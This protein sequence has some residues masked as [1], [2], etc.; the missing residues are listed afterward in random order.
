MGRLTGKRALIT[1]GGSGIGRATA[2]LFAAE[3]ATVIAADLR[4]HDETASGSGGKIIP[5]QCN[6]ADAAAVEAMMAFARSEMGGLD[7][8]FNNAGIGRGGKRLHEIPLK[9]WDDVID[10]N[11]RGVFLVLKYGLPVMMDSGGGSVI[12]TASTSAFKAVYGNGAYTPAKAAVHLM[13]N[14]AAVEY[15]G[16]NIRVNAVAPGPILTPIYDTVP[17]AMKEKIINALPLGR[18]GTADEVAKVVLF[19]ASDNSSFV[20]GATYLVDGGRMVG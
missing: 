16:D 7:I 11:L 2:W 19:L 3:G 14:L 5:H 12:N 13:T 20:T 17:P 1:G 18:M 4:G 8:I 6:V 9:D 10:V 15:A